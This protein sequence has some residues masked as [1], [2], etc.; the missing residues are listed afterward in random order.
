ITAVLASP[1]TTTAL[2]V[3]PPSAFVAIVDARYVN[4]GRLDVRGLDLEAAYG[5]D[6]AGGR[7]DLAGTASHLLRYGQQLTPTSPVLSRGGR[8]AGHRR[9][10]R[11]AAVPAGRPAQPRGVRRR[12]HRSAATL[13]GD[14]AARSL[15]VRHPVRPRVLQR[16]RPNPPRAPRPPQP[17]PAGTVVP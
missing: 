5:V 6:L 16:H 11:R 12:R 9:A 1:D 8:R 2:G 4:T 7:L 3:F 14:R 10:S 17:D 13:A 15:P